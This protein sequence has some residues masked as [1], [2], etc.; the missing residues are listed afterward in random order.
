MWNID[1]AGLNRVEFDLDLLAILLTKHVI[2][3]FIFS[4][5]CITQLATAILIKITIWLLAGCM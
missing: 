2:F 1:L 5:E 3:A 4:S